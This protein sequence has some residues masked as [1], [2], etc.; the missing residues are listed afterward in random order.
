MPDFILQEGQHL[1]KTAEYE[2]H[3]RELFG[4]HSRDWTEQFPEAVVARAVILF[5]KSLAASAKLNYIRKLHLYFEYGASQNTDPLIPSGTFICQFCAY[6]EAQ[7]YS[8][9]SVRNAVSAIKFFF[10]RQRKPIPDEERIVEALTLIAT[11][12]GT[13]RSEN[14]LRFTQEHIRSMAAAMPQNEAPANLRNRAFILGSYGGGMEPR[15]L[16]AWTWEAMEIKEGGA[17]IRIPGEK[18]ISIAR[19]DNK[20]VDP[21][22]A[23]EAWRDLCLKRLPSLT[24]PVLRR[25]DAWG[26]IWPHALSVGAMIKILRDVAKSAGLNHGRITLL[27]IRH[28][29]LQNLGLLGL[30]DSR[31]LV[32]SRVSKLREARKWSRHNANPQW[33]GNRKRRKS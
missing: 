13:R 24:G 32:H 5:D 30:E 3:S 11:A 6:L 33:Q 2:Q 31:F 12:Q 25:F 16:R 8:Y 7:G 22:R 28:G 10:R 4:M 27:S 20:V 19:L 17:T 14:I 1:E 29:Y 9:H 18:T 21:V 15:V 26:N 23:I